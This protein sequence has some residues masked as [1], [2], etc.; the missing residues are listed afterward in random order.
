MK[1]LIPFQAKLDRDLVFALHQQEK[2][3]VVAHSLVAATVFLLLRGL[4][5]LSTLSIWILGILAV[6]IFRGYRAVKVMRAEDVHANHKSIYWWHFGTVVACGLI[7]SLG[8]VAVLPHLDT[9]HRA[10][11][12]MVLSALGTGAVVTLSA[13]PATYLGFSIG[14]MAPAAIALAMQPTAIDRILAGL[15]LASF[16]F[17]L[18]S[19]KKARILLWGHLL[20]QYRNEDVVRDLAAAKVN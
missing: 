11:V 10:I 13:R 1:A 16:V 4:A 9:P 17:G 19:S 6:S 12:I 8:Y 14:V 3:A 2:S 7:W 5:P 15:T 18:A 20:Q